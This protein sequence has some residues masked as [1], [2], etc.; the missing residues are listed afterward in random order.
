[1]RSRILFVSGCHAD[2]SRLSQMLRGL[3]MGMEYVECLQQARAKLQ[4][5]E[6]DVILTEAVLPDGNWLD[7]MHL[8]RA[9]P[10]DMQVV[11]TDRQADG[12]FWSEVLNL[13]AYD[14][15]PQPFYEPE[16]RRILY[17]ACTR[18]GETATTAAG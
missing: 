2:A 11:V 8:A 1:M 5:R 14:L 10:G 9:T 17:N 4:Q 18:V 3:P 15:L 12:R 13:G 6:Y 7:T 16:V